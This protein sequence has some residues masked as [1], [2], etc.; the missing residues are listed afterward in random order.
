M[1]VVRTVHVGCS[2][3]AGPS[4]RGC[5]Q[6]LL[7]RQ[8]ALILLTFA[9]KILGYA[10]ESQYQ[11]PFMKL[12]TCF[13]CHFLNFFFQFLFQA[14]I[15]AFTSDMIPRLV[16]YYAYSEN[17]DSPMSGYINNSLSVFQISDF[18]ERNKPKQN[19]EGL[20]I[21]RLV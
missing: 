9:E 12:L 18:P 8:S 15:V 2:P 21:C 5:S 1:P 7:P 11:N 10:A 19:P 6:H 16:Y 20:D 3:R 4:G 13:V 17:E 14:F